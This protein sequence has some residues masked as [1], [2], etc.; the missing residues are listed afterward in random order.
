[1]FYSSTYLQKG[2][3]KGSDVWVGA[4]RYKDENGNWKAIR[5]T[6]HTKYKRDARKMLNEWQEEMEY[7]KQ[8]AISYKTVREAVLE[9]LDYQ[10]NLNQISIVSYQD[11]VEQAEY[12]IFPYIGDKS[13]Y[14][15]KP[16]EVQDFISTLSKKYKPSSVRTIFSVLSKVLKNAFKMGKMRQD[17]VAMV[18]LPEQKRKEINYLDADGRRKFQS[19][20]SASKKFYIPAMIAFYAGMRAGEICALRWCDINYATGIITLKKNAKVYKDENGN[21]VVEVSDTK[22][23]QNRTIPL[24]SKLKTILQ[25]YEEEIQAE[26]TDYIIPD[27]NPRLLCTSFLKWST[28]NKVIGTLGKPIGLHGLRHT[29]ATLGV[30]SGMDIKS[31]SSIL[32][33]SSAAMTLDIYASDDENAKQ[34]NMAILDAMLTNEEESDF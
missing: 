26:A 10:R 25:E 20:I 4:L 15:L 2:K 6:F 19:C 34:T 12:A 33:H 7:K 16:V 31:L 11:D 14:D 5:K 8:A 3:N 13:F 18:E 27:R 23:Y 28:R 9:Y 1:M 22:N 32:G 21:T 17:I 24:M 29:F 30:Q